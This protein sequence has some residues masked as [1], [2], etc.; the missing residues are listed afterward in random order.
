MRVQIT[1]WLPLTLAVVLVAI[2]FL[3]AVTDSVPALIKAYQSDPRAFAELLVTLAGWLLALAGLLLAGQDAKRGMA[4]N[5]LLKLHDDEGALEQGEAKQL[6]WKVTPPKDYSGNIYRYVREYLQGLPENE[7][8]KLDW[9]RRRLSN[10]W[11]GAAR[12][13][14]LGSLNPNQV[15]ESV[16]PPD[17]LTILEPLEAITAESIDPEWKPRPWPPMRLLITWY[18]RQGRGK[19]ARRLRAEV[20]AQPDMYEASHSKQS[21]AYQ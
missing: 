3:I 9:A 17:I 8:E 16:G 2:A 19:E 18:G 4:F 20:P 15:F 5:A 10:F 13:V 14:D 12:L 6:I 1:P 11:Y 7:R 21:A